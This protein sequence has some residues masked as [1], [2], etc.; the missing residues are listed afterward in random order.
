MAELL[1]Q[2]IEQLMV[3]FMLENEEYAVPVSQIKEVI[4]IP[5]IT[6]VPE[7]LD[8]VEGII[9]I[10]GLVMP[11]VNLKRRL[12]LSEDCVTNSARIMIAELK[13]QTVGLVVDEVNEVKRIKMAD[14]QLPPA[15]VER[16]SGTYING[17]FYNGDTMYIV[18]DLE[19]VLSDRKQDGLLALTDGER[20]HMLEMSNG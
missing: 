1:N 16:G 20:V 9:N 19:Y 3:V 8:Y 14:I 7:C 18:I 15:M 17:V 13:S 5:P 12:R 11:V 10:R 6:N 2:E 4:K